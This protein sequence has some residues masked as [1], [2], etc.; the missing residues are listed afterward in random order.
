ML[1]AP[2]CLEQ[3]MKLLYQRFL[4]DYSDQKH[5]EGTSERRQQSFIRA[6]G[7]NYWSCVR[8]T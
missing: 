6:L 1:E 5:E 4:L 2:N 8:S 7:V 3:I